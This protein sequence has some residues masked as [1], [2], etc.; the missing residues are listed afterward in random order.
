MD[1]Q[2]LDEYLQKTY[3]TAAE[4]PWKTAP[5]YAVYRHADNKKW[6]A[7]IMDISKRKI[8]FA[9]D[10]IISVVNLKI[11]PSLVGA[12]LENDGVYP[13]YHMNKNHWITVELTDKTSLEQISWLVEMSYDNTKI[14]IR[15][16]AGEK[17]LYGK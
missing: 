6:F 13:A 4:Y 3:S 10:E 12:L 7:V 2:E 5:S 17:E 16:R 1:R 11:E 14:K 8:G 15:N 9:D